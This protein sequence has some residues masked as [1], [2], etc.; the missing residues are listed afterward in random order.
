MTPDAILE[1]VKRM[2]QL[3][4]LW[5]AWHQAEDKYGYR[6]AYHA[7]LK[8][9]EWRAKR[10][11]VL[12]RANKKCECCGEADAWQVHHL[13]YRYKFREPLWDLKAVCDACHVAMTALDNTPRPIVNETPVIAEQEED[14]KPDGKSLDPRIGITGKINEEM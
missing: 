14:A 7:Y 2:S 1:Y 6:K 4:P 3:M 8:S 9:P 5:M 10:D 12:L 11:M 13:S